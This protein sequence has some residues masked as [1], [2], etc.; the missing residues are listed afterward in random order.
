[1]IECIIV[2]LLRSLDHDVSTAI[3]TASLLQAQMSTDC[4]ASFI[5]QRS[6]VIC[7]FRSSHCS[8][9]PA[10]SCSLTGPL[11]HRSPV[12]VY[13]DSGHPCFKNL[14]STIPVDVIRVKLYVNSTQ[15]GSRSITA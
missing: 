3:E 5:S 10:S 1:M 14:N 15:L 12:I 4:S 13:F 8:I 6:A 11:L 7:T 2:I 9:V